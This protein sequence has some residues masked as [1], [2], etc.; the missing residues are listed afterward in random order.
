MLDFIVEVIICVLSIYGF[1]SIIQDYINLVKQIDELNAE[2]STDKQVFLHTLFD[3]EEKGLV[4]ETNRLF[5]YKSR[6]SFIFSYV[7]T[8]SS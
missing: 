7:R 5:L 8:N 4:D 2:V 6:I 1:F 3:Y